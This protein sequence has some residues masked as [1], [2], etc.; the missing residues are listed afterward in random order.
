MPEDSC[1]S[2]FCL[3]D[4]TACSTSVSTFWRRLGMTSSVDYKQVIASICGS[5]ISTI[6]LNPINVV[7]VHLQ[8][9]SKS[10][11][12]STSRSQARLS[13]ALKVIYTRNGIKSFWSGTST[14][15]VMSL[16]NTVLYMATYETVKGVLHSYATSDQMKLLYT[17]LSGALARVVSVTLISP[18]ELVRTLQQGNAT[19]TRQ[20]TL[21]NSTAAKTRHKANSFVNICKEIVRTKGLGG[22]YGGWMATILRDCPYSAIYWFSFEYLRPMYKNSLNSYAMSNVALS[23]FLSGATSGLIAACV[24]HPFDVVKTK[25][26]LAV[27]S[28]STPSGAQTQLASVQT[29]SVSSAAPDALSASNSSSVASRLWSICRAEGIPGLYRG[30]SMRLLTV[31]PGSAIMITV[32]DTIKNM[33]F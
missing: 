12:S 5:F 7:K 31:I 6:V 19:P 1:D 9:Q 8:A 11:A 32:Y 20:P 26:Q 17:G 30:L 15:L 4:S 23:T 18:L 24:T 22:L 25:Q 27:L 21:S 16:P 10:S 28:H 3:K 2:L 33:D 13:A 14:G 29:T